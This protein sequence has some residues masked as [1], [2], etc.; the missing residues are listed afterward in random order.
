M[1]CVDILLLCTLN[2]SSSETTPAVLYNNW[3]VS[4]IVA[5]L[6]VHSTL[7][8]VCHNL[9]EVFVCGMCSSVLT[10]VDGDLVAVVLSV[11]ILVPSV[12]DSNCVVD[13]ESLL[14]C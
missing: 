5:V 9:C 10:I 4:S 11:W 6:I 2:T 12:L 3:F 7:L 14:W 8:I 13:E 1:S